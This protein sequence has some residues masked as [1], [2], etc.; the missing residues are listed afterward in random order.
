VD[1]QITVGDQVFEAEIDD[2]ETGKAIAAVLPIEGSANVWGDEIY[3]EI[4]VTLVEGP[5]AR[6]EVEVGTLAYWPPGNAFCI[7]YG[8]TPVS[9]GATPRAYS[10]VNEFGRI[11][12]DATELRGTR[13]G[14]SVRIEAA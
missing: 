12:G 9:A 1:V 11:H 2:N 13:S 14:A 8:P 4:P 6:E 7:F 5:E 10:P 3:F